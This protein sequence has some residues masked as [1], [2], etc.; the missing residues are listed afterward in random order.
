MFFPLMMVLVC[1]ETGLESD[2][3]PKLSFDSFY[4]TTETEESWL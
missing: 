3:C 1:A 4:T 2:Q